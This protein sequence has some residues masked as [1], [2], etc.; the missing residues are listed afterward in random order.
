MTVSNIVQTQDHGPDLV[1]RDRFPFGRNWTS[2]L[3]VLDESRIQ[4]AE[5]SLSEML[6][7]DCIAGATFLDAGSGSGLFSLAAMRLGARRVHSFD[8]D[9]DSVKCTQEMRRKYFP[10]AEHWTVEQ[11]SVLDPAYLQ[12]LGQ[13]DIVYSWGVLHHTGDMW[14]ALELVTGLVDRS[15][16]LFI[17]IYNDQA[18]VSDFWTSVKRVYNMGWLGRTAVLAAFLPYFVGR[19]LL[20]DL[21]RRK[22]PLARYREYQRIRGMSALHDWKDW[23]G[24]YPFEVAKPEEVFSFFQARGFTLSKLTTCASQHGCNEFVFA[25]TGQSART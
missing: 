3:R 12:R 21:I 23:L 14:R 11:A 22:N 19:G 16:R 13:W 15:G 25:R 10:A 20:V 7:R 6:G 18:W 2:F 5:R 8:F 1:G 17:A 4:E 9:P 24:G